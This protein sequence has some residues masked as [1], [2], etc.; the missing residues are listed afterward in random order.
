MIG[1]FRSERERTRIGGREC[2]PRPVGLWSVGEEFFPLRY[3]CVLCILCLSNRLSSPRRYQ[4]LGL[5]LFN[6][7]PLSRQEVGVEAG[8]FRIQ[9]APSS[10][11]RNACK[12]GS[13]DRS[14]HRNRHH[15][16]PPTPSLHRSRYH[17]RCFSYRSSFFFLYFSHREFVLFQ[18]LP[19]G[20]FE[21][22]R[23]NPGRALVPDNLLGDLDGAILGRRAF[24][25]RERFKR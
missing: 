19:Q 12:A 3:S 8:G 21:L 18:E 15:I 22:P 16:R 1:A 2:K 17:H 20:P 10:D 25:V 11:P 6:R 23:D 5:T 7:S 4:R 9:S 14:T 13:R 24:H